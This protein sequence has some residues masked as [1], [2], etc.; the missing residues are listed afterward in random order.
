V[1]RGI[2]LI[3]GGR[4]RGRSPS[5]QRCGDIQTTPVLEANDFHVDVVLI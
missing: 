4:Q 5:M 1:A 2:D 3:A